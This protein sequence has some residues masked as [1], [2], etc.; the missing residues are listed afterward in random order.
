M[1][2]YYIIFMA[3]LQNVD[4]KFALVNNYKPQMDRVSNDREA[5]TT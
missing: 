4:L 3:S 1:A 2:I 5:Q